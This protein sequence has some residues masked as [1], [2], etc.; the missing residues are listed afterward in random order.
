ML[1]VFNL[2]MARTS[3]AAR[4]MLWSKVIFSCSVLFQHNAYVK[5]ISAA[6]TD[7]SITLQKPL[8]RL[9]SCSWAGTDKEDD[10]EVCRGPMAIT[11]LYSG[12]ETAGTQLWLQTSKFRPTTGTRYHLKCHGAFEAATWAWQM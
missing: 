7:P 10:F 4:D 2:K 8:V 5:S 6:D 9:C 12:T 1:L 3:Y 11:A